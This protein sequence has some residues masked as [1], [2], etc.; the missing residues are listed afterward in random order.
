MEFEQ[1]EA[2]EQRLCRA[3]GFC[4]DGTLFLHVRIRESEPIRAYK[5]AG[6]QLVDSPEGKVTMRQPCSGFSK[7]NC[8]TYHCRPLRCGEFKCALLNLAS[9]GAVTESNALDLIRETKKIR[10]RYTDLL[11]QIFPDF[12]QKPVVSTYRQ[13]RKASKHLS[14]EALKLFRARKSQLKEYRERLQE[15]LDLHF[16]DRQEKEDNDISEST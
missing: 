2:L 15:A 11:Y 1:T 12:E 10:S 5:K 3:C 13:I 4:C 6:L 16:Y 8:Q 14:G 7:G 9:E